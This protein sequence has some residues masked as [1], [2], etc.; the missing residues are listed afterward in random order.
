MPNPQIEY[1]DDVTPGSNLG[2]ILRDGCQTASAMSA[3]QA[4]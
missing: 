3:A 4:L 1:D 2:R